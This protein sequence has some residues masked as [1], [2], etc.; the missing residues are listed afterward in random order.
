M[1]RHVSEKAHPNQEAKDIRTLGVNVHNRLLEL[2]EGDDELAGGGII[3]VA[4]VHR[5]DDA[6]LHTR[7]MRSRGKAQ[8]M[9]AY[10]AHRPRKGRTLEVCCR[11]AKGRA[12]GGGTLPPTISWV[13]SPGHIFNT[14]EPVLRTR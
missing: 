4:I 9:S 5:G 12:M 11:A 10:P 7:A 1:V 3:T 2:V 14:T 6:S 13:H 8:P